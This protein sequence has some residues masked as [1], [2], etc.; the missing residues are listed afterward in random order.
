MTHVL[1]VGAGPTGLTAA[2]ELSRLGIDVRIVE[3]AT[4]PSTTSRAL[5]VQA[6]TVELLR[7]RGVADEMLRLG[8]RASA[9]TLYA[10]GERLAGIE[11]HRMA[12][13]FNFLL[14]LAQSE[15]ERLLTE[16]LG[17]QGVE[18]ERGVEFVSLTQDDAAAHVVLRDAN[19]RV[20]TVTASYVIAADGSHSAVR[21]SLGLGFEGRSL[22]QNYVLGD[23]HLAGAVP[24]DQLSM[25]LAPK[26]FLAVFPMG[27]GRFRFMATD[28]D[29]VTGDAGEPSLADIQRLYDR[30]A[31]LG[32]QL[33]DLNWS[34]RFRISSRHMTTLR[35]GRVFFGGDAAHVHSPAGGQGMNAGIQDMINLGWKVAM[36]LR[37][38]ARP[39][40]LDTYETDRLPVIRQLVA[41][42][43]RATRVFNSTNPVVHALLTRLAPKVLSRTTVQDKAA[44][45][46]GQIAASYHGRPLARRGGRIGSLRAG[47]R[48]PDVHLTEGRLYDL[49]DDSTLTLFISGGAGRI[50]DAH[51]RWD[52]V[53]TVR[54][55]TLPAELADGAAWLLVRPDGYLAAAGSAE[56]GRRLNRWL[57]RWLVA[58]AHPT[59]ASSASLASA[60]ARPSSSSISAHSAVAATHN[61]AD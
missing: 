17:R 13:E 4:A 19:G 26:G 8:N 35:A 25:F 2:V 53:I 3:R 12:S 43:E 20:E 49:L 52:D 1:V 60:S 44:P 5:G 14:M 48:I 61:R 36:V 7:P 37:G 55:T 40:L 18:V 21:K 54:E 57:D 15:T 50:L 31:H 58:R 28:P 33:Y 39:E 32:A 23:V 56:Q 34:S 41:M 10:G 16:Q 6:R 51:H 42:T 47:D 30:T 29:G 9:T 27:D 22:A 59:S 45:R 24:Q 38:A 46:L 11:L